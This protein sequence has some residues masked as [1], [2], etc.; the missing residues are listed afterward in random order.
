MI[1]DSKIQTKINYTFTTVDGVVILVPRNPK[2]N[3]FVWGFVMEKAVSDNI[4]PSV[5][6]NEYF[7]KPSF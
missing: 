2:C 3:V 4:I 6:V 7:W 1:D 5:G